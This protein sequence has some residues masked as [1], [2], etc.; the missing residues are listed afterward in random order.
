MSSEDST[1][2]PISDLKGDASSQAGPDSIMAS[3][4]LTDSDI[5]DV[6]VPDEKIEQL[7]AKSFKIFDV[8]KSGVLGATQCFAIINLH[9]TGDQVCDMGMFQ[10]VFEELDDDDSGAVSLDQFLQ[11]YRETERRMAASLSDK[12]RSRTA[13]YAF[14]AIAL[15]PL[16]MW[17]ASPSRENSK[18]SL[19]RWVFRNV[20]RS[21]NLPYKMRA[22]VTGDSVVGF[23]FAYIV[24]TIVFLATTIGFF[25]G[26]S[27]SVKK[28]TVHVSSI[29]FM[30]PFSL[31]LFNAAL[32]ALLMNIDDRPNVMEQRRLLRACPLSQMKIET[33]KSSK[34]EN[35]TAETL[36]A[37]VLREN[38]ADR[39]REKFVRRC[40]YWAAV[41][42]SFAFASMPFFARWYHTYNWWGTCATYDAV[43]GDVCTAS[44]RNAWRWLAVQSAILVPAF[45]YWYVKALGTTY[46]NF[47]EQ[48]RLNSRI[49]DILHADSA[50]SLEAP[51][52]EFDHA[53]NVVAWSALRHYLD[54]FKQAAVRSIEVVVGGTVM[55]M[56]LVVVMLIY[57]RV[58][59]FQ[60]LI[61]DS[62]SF[63]YT[64]FTAVMIGTY[65]VHP[66]MSMG[67]L[68]NL[69][70]Q[71]VFG[72]LSSEKWRL[73]LAGETA[74]QAE[75]VEEWRHAQGLVRGQYELQSETDTA[76]KILGVV[77]NDALLFS[78]GSAI[79]SGIAAWVSSIISSG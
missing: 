55:V 58:K 31:Q 51:L 21:Y 56:L 69:R 43:N 40:I 62:V 68:I 23:W 59:G 19:T 14:V 64:G 61:N 29:E 44:D 74:K 5:T 10:E 79:A 42:A 73:T 30:V 50:A 66:L 28:Y 34:D 11:V 16:F 9:L 25:T 65:M 78:V 71:S 49:E 39:L 18:N 76:F 35:V 48:V 72:F 38:D 15:W 75:A 17:A 70:K 12:P 6:V 54:N 22:Y 45:G 3:P 46:F 60:S 33:S 8:E 1:S 32:I 27:L 47:A 2:I 24:G 20:V 37:H 53:E 67:V 13:L 26:I 4:D 41:L 7:L 36:L 63:C 52:V 57:Q 77:V